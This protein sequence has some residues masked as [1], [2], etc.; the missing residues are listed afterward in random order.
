M[1]M[2]EA[3][4]QKD[5]SKVFYLYC[6]ENFSTLCRFCCQV[7]R[8]ESEAIFNDSSDETLNESNELIEKIQY[9]LYDNVSF[10]Q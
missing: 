3:L 2:S 7:K 6:L 8:S 4:S 10:I 1:K 9:T 5:E